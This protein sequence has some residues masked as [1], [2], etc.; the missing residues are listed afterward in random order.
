MLFD[1]QRDVVMWALRKGRAALFLDTGMGKTFCQLEWARILNKKTLIIA[2]LSVARQ[3]IREAKK[4]DIELHYV[5]SDEELNGNQ[6]SITNYE[7]IQKFDFSAFGAIVLDESSILKAIDGK[8]RRRLIELCSG[9][10]YRLCCTATPAPND[11]AE[12][13]NHAEFLGICKRSEMLAMFFINA[14]KVKEYFVGDTLIREKQSNKKG[15]QWRLKYH[16]L[17]SF[18]RWLASWAI[19]M[20]KPSDLGYEDR[21]FV[22]PPLSI[23]LVSVPTYHKPNGTLF[24]MGLKG[25]S[26]RHKIRKQTL[27][28]RIDRSLELINTNG[29][30]WIIWCGLD[31]ESKQISSQ[32]NDYREVKGS[33]SSE[34]KAESFENFQDGKYRIL[35]TKPKIGQFGM[36]FQNAH[37]MIFLGLGD[38][39]ESY[40]QCIRRQWRFGQREPVNAYIVLS[41][42]ETEIYNNVLRKERMATFMHSEMMKH[43]KEFE[44]QEL[45][46]AESS[47]SEYKNRIV[48]DKFYKAIRGDSAV[49]L[50]RIEDNSVDLSVYS[51][52]FADLYTYTDSE[53]DL[54]NCKDWDEF[55]GH[56]SFII[57][58]LLRVTKS[59]R[60]T[61]VHSA[62]IPAMMLKD[63]YIGMKDFPG[64]LIKAYEAGGWVFHGR[65]IVAKNP[66]SQA[67][68]TKSKALLFT[69]LRKDSIACRP[70]ILD[71]ILIFIKQ[72]ENK[73]PITPVENKEMDNEVWIDWAGGIWTGIH[74]SDTLKYSQARDKDDEKH[75]CPL[76]LG[77]IERCIKLYSNPGETVLTPFMGI[78]S[79]AYQAIR[80]GRKAIGIELKESYFNIAIENLRKISEERDAYKLFDIGDS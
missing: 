67:I 79:E 55:F 47:N 5:R 64:A 4:I 48:E 61:C 18:Y 29:N 39:F 37:N 77:T 46:M 26:D 65:A 22:L 25:I 58:E 54:G 2:P 63:G 7:H 68:R 21:G 11:Q 71:H 34:Y 50:V 33:D 73:V 19:S 6:I 8:T 51:P 36:N 31:V 23:K 76:Q 24:F 13:G 35:I 28:Q 9:I 45:G 42:L 66:Q 17:K 3:T 53:R 52:P 38:S 44:K 74:E 57:K 80:F 20:K 75:I 43:I 78:G 56:Y 60:I 62:D 12:L 27:E 32:L 41:D 30:Q 16:G 59:G 70:A 40:Y 10:P 1:F 15:T 14:N 49:E 69:Q 72:G